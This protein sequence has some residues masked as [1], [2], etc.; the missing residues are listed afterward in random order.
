MK[1][2][3]LD[4]YTI[5][6]GDTSW[7]SVEKLGD[8]TAY[9]R[10]EPDEIIARAMPAEIL[11]TNK[12][13]L[14]EQIF[15][16]LPNLKYVSVTATG[17][18]VVDAAAARARGIAVSNVPE[19][20][21]QSVAQHVFALIL[22]L[23]HQPTRHDRAIRDG[24]WQEANDFC[25]WLDPLNELAGKTIGI[26]GFGRIGQAVAKLAA[27]FGMKVLAYN[28]REKSTTG[29]EFAWCSLNEL[30]SAADFVSLHCP[31]T[32]STTG[33]VNDTFLAK[34]K[35][36]AVL[37]NASRGGLVV[38]QD[39]A[40]ALNGGKIRA[41]LVDV[42]SQEPINSDNPLLQAKNCLM[43]PHIA[44]ATVESRQR[45]IEITAGNIKAFQNGKPVNVVN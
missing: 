18:N 16:E 35:P 42:A 28:P 1:I 44:W 38:E 3:A 13:V 33:M 31:Q 27:A 40:D 12:A 45:L 9:D 14:N 20:S 17:F 22:N 41:A 39:L 19:Y 43:S 30:L 25:F 10:S 23:I 37:I 6:P 24:K 11:L 36:Q 26:V 34:M 2:V 4:A 5:N 29:I 32:E 15:A 21:T 7:S 8:F